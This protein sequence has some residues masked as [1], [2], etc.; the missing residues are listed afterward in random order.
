MARGKF[1]S[2]FFI[3]S[4][5]KLRVSQLE[6]EKGQSTLK[7]LRT[8]LAQFNK[9][10]DDGNECQDHGVSEHVLHTCAAINMRKEDRVVCQDK[11][12]PAFILRL[13]LVV[14]GRQVPTDAE[15]S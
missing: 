6:Y 5:T 7:V 12:Q 4:V 11:M 3:S 2:G 15:M 13:D 9:A 8:S 10:R 1:L 14:D